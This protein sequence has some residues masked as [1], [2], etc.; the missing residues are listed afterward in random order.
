[1]GDI[2]E[3]GPEGLRNNVAQDAV[4]D[5]SVQT[6]AEARRCLELGFRIM[7]HADDGDMRRG[8]EAMGL[9]PDRVVGPDFGTL[10]L[11]IRASSVG[12][13]LRPPIT[14]AQMEEEGWP[15]EVQAIFRKRL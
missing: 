5:P 11:A 4:G 14:E 10:D 6:P 1:M 9:D 15:E 13:S 2:S 8:L 3:I 7:A 12:R